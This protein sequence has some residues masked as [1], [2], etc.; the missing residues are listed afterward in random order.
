MYLGVAR[1]TDPRERMPTY[2][3]TRPQLPVDAPHTVTAHLSTASCAANQTH[4]FAPFTQIY[5][6]I[7]LL[8]AHP[9]LPPSLWGNTYVLFLDYASHAP[10]ITTLSCTLITITTQHRTRTAAFTTTT[11][12]PP[13][14]QHMTHPAVAGRL[15]CTL[16]FVRVIC[17]F[18]Y[19]HT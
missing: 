8:L 16:T 18:A 1:A 5:N 7:S 4:N 13:R 14:P 17:I 6:F 3:N 12:T 2:Y 19:L 10:S 11:T 9:T 15:R